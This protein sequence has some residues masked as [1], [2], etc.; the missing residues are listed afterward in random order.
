MLSFFVAAKEWE[1]LP[2]V[3]RH[4]FRAAASEVNL[5][6]MAKYDALNPGALER[7]IA[8]GAKLVPFPPEIMRL[9]Q[10]ATFEYFELE[11]SRNPELGK[12]YQNWRSFREPQ[13]AWHRVAEHTYA[14]FVYTTR[15]QR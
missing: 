10:K 7:L 13:F 12:I 5:D 6:L 1:K 4:A 15:V 9:A 2:D 3:Y 14:N 11:A 8:S